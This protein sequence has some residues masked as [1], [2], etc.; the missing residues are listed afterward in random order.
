MG[1]RTSARVT[2]AW[3]ARIVACRATSAC[4]C[5]PTSTLVWLS[6]VVGSLPLPVVGDHGGQVDSGGGVG[7]AELDDRLGAAVAHKGV[8]QLAARPGDRHVLPAS[9][10]ARCFA[11]ASAKG[12]SSGH[13]AGFA[14]EVGGREQP[15]KN[16]GGVGRQWCS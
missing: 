2:R 8:E 1:P 4:S 6:S 7:G 10:S 12:V 15:V 9:A 14:F 13:G 16:S 3:P 5:A 11:E